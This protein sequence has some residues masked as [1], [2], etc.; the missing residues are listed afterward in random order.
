MIN[1]HTIDLHIK[2]PSEMR[3]EEKR[4]SQREI[5]A[6]RRKFEDES[7]SDDER[8]AALGKLVEKGDMV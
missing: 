1:A 6:A 2:T 3:E 5:D 7:A 8:R 4:D